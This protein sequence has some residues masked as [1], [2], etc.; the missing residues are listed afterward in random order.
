MDRWWSRTDRPLPPPKSER[1]TIQAP[2]GCL[3]CRSRK[4]LHQAR[5]LCTRCYARFLSRARERAVPI[6][7]YLDSLGFKRTVNNELYDLRG[8]IAAAS[9]AG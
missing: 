6:A 8:G 3:E 7:A 4:R 2:L 9:R 5:G 1:W